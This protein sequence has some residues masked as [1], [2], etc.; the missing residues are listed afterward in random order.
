LC[1]RLIEL[2]GRE[3]RWRY[4]QHDGGPMFAWT[5]E[6]FGTGGLFD[7]PEPTR[8]G[9]YA[10]FVYEPIGRGSRSGTATTFAWPSTPRA[11][12]SF[13]ATPTPARCGSSAPGKPA[14]DAPGADATQPP[15]L[16]ARSSARVHPDRA[17][18]SRS[19]RET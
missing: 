4:F 12:T 9:R 11:C 5:V 8:T 16:L 6:P 7:E 14:N 10:S 2:Y 15:T 18:H 19:R 1:E 3:P 17:P 13:A